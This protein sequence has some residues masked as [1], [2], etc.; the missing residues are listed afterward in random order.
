MQK[1]L[2]TDNP[3]QP[4]SSEAAARRPTFPLPLPAFTS[5]SLCDGATQEKRRLL[6]RNDIPALVVCFCHPG[7]LP[8]QYSKCSLA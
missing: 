6:I 1:T 8:R 3:H 4:Y 5:G 2:R 7:A